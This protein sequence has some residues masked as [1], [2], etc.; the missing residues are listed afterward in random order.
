MY[1]QKSRPGREPEA[2][3]TT[4]VPPIL[5]AH[6]LGMPVLVVVLDETHDWRHLVHATASARPGQHVRV[7]IVGDVRPPV[8]GIEQVR[9]DLTLQFESTSADVLDVWC[10]AFEGVTR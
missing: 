8:F 10:T 1:A 6:R 2:A 4:D 3:S 7:V 5:S 9:T